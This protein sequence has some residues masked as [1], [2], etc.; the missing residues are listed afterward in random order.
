MRRRE[1]RG[2]ALFYLKGFTQPFLITEKFFGAKR[3]GF[4]L[5]ELL[6]V[7]VIFSIILA[8]FLPLSIKSFRSLQL[9]DSTRNI[10]S[11]MR[12]LQDKAILE[13]KT[14]SL[15]FDIMASCYSVSAKTDGHFKEFKEIKTALLSKKSLGSN[16][17][18]ESLVIKQEK[19]LDKEKSSI[20]FYPDGSIDEVILVLTNSLGEK[21]TI[22]TNLS[23]KID[24]IRE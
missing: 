12:Y 15:D 11:L 8:V 22:E 17:K 2:K 6:V 1:I 19:F 13:R 9:L 16:L 3:A 18:I 5:I 23:G 10:T 21:I 7:I 4:T 14:Y 20:Y 24:V